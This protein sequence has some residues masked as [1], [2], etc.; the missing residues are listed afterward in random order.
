MVYMAIMLLPGMN[1]TE[2]YITVVIDITWRIGV[3][4]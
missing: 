2:Q 1:P 3:L 4:T